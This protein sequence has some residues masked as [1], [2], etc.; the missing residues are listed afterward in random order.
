MSPV[1]CNAFCASTG[2]DSIAAPANTAAQ[3]TSNNSFFIFLSLSLATA[4]T[5][6]EW[7]SA[8]WRVTVKMDYRVGLVRGC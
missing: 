7:R 1:R 5:L 2:I 8:L 4:Y 3:I 6:W